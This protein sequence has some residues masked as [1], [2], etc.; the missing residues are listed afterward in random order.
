MKNGVHMFFD[1][2]RA[3]QAWTKRC[4]R[5]HTHQ[6][7]HGEVVAQSSD[8]HSSSDNSDDSEPSTFITVSPGSRSAGSSVP[9]PASTCT[10]S[11]V[12]LEA[13]KEED[14]PQEIPL[15]LYLDDPTSIVMPVDRTPSGKRT[16]ARIQ[17]GSHKRAKPRT[18]IKAATSAATSRLPAP[19]E[20]AAYTIANNTASAN[21]AAALCEHAELPH[22]SVRAQPHW[23][24]LRIHRHT[25]TRGSPILLRPAATPAPASRMPV[26]TVTTPARMPTAHSVTTATTPAPASRALNA[27]SVASSRSVSSAS[28]MSVSSAATEARLPFL[29]LRASVSTGGSGASPFG[30]GDFG[31]SSK[32]TGS[33]RGAGTSMATSGKG[34]E[35]A[36]SPT[37]LLYNKDTRTLY[38]DPYVHNSFLF[39]HILADVANIFLQCKSGT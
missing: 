4:R 1:R 37:R 36:S 2:A 22:P 3:E 31:W 32:S 27:A 11:V 12:K 14:I 24:D 35:R 33:K 9:M 28:S 6:H 30:R 39:L 20:A 25:A 29:D 21:A 17:P 16:A 38:K 26:A 19:P 23:H 10:K 8:R 15:P 18:V 5:R 7:E 13:K 34:K